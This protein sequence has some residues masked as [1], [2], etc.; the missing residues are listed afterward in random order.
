MAERA[1]SRGF[2][3]ADMN[4]DGKLDIVVA[5]QWHDFSYF[6]NTTTNG[7]TALS[8]RVLEPIASA[9][10]GLGDRW[11]PSDRRPWLPGRRRG[12]HRSHAGWAIAN[13]ARRRRQRGTRA[14]SSDVHIGLGKTAGNAALPVSIAWRTAQGSD[15]RSHCETGL[16]YRRP[17][18]AGLNIQKE[19]NSVASQLAT[20]TLAGS[21]PMT[22]RNQR[23]RAWG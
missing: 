6:K 9:G 21:Q 19:S 18:A 8:L 2:S 16:A 22:K 13:R 11:P 5:N 3:L 14:R 10:F 15:D 12:R 20:A 1:V 17:S 7:N 4:G 23:I